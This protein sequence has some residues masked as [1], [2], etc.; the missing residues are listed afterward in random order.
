M[1]QLHRGDYKSLNVYLVNGAG[2]GVC[3]LPLAGDAPVTQEQLDGDGCFIPLK[4]GI[5]PNEGTMTHES[6]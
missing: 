6:R 5:S 2:G 3:S 4:S 1:R